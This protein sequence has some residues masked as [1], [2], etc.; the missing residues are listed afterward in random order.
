MSHFYGSITGNAG[1]ATRAGSKS[2]GY[3]AWA[4]NSRAQVE[5]RLFHHTDIDRDTA[6]ILLRPSTLT[7]DYKHLVIADGID[8]DALIEHS[9]DPTIQ[10][11]VADAANAL[12]QASWR[13]RNLSGHVGQTVL[14]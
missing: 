7:Y 8:I 10:G 4:Q 1:S 3:T 6:D 11:L 12:E 13:A 9:D 5:V 2:S 14:T